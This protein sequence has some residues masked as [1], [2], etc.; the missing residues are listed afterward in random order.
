VLYAAATLAGAMLEILV[1]Y[2]AV[3]KG[4]CLSTIEIPDDVSVTEV[5]SSVLSADWAQN[6]ELTRTIGSTWFNKQTSAVLIV[7][8]CVAHGEKNYLTEHDASGLR[9]RAL[10]LA[11]FVP[12]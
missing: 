12:V 10:L 3:P 11:H 6:L 9:T 2:A 1:R 4:M 7:P 5:S 8:S